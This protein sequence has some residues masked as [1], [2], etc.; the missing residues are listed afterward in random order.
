MNMISTVLGLIAV[1]LGIFGL[2]PLLGWLNWLAL[3]LSFWGMS[4]GLYARDKSTGV[5]INFLV[6]VLAILRLFVGGG[7]V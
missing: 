6:M 1:A 5:T 4:F 2:F 3:F 7:I